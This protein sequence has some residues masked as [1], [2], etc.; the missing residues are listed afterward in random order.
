MLIESLPQQP[1]CAQPEG[2]PG[3]SIALR[4]TSGRPGCSN[5]PAF[6]LRMS[7]SPLIFR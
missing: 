6:H 7:A 4:M 3:I 5:S 1:A 2:I